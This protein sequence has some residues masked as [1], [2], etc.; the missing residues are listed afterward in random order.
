MK[1]RYWEIERERIMEFDYN[2]KNLIKEKRKQKAKLVAK[3]KHETIENA[4][5][6]IFETRTWVDE[7]SPNFK[8]MYE[9]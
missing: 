8:N 2:E 7:N 9:K 5:W 1:P 6:Y 4:F 3:T